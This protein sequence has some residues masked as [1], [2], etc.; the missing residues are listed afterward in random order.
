MAEKEVKI[1]AKI[2]EKK[3]PIDMLL[4]NSIALQKTLATLATDLKT[5]NQKVSSLLE[6]FEAA[7]KT[8]R[9]KPVAP[10][11]AKAEIPKELL[12]KVNSL[13]EQNKTIARGLLLLEQAIH[14]IKMPETEEAETTESKPLPEL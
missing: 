10:S 5:L 13:V 3:A 14:E 9:E 7:G 12:D 6:L 2:P 1:K 11:M 4:E 8:F